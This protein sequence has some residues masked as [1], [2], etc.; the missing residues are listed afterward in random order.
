M[1]ALLIALGVIDLVLGTYRLIRD[2]VD[3][4]KDKK[5]RK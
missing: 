1:E 3:Y 5:G 2:G 4:F